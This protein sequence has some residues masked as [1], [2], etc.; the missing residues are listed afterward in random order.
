MLDQIEFREVLKHYRRNLRITQG[1]LASL[2]RVSRPTI[3]NFET[4]HSK[5]SEQS[6]ESVRKAL[7]ELIKDRASAVGF[8]PA[9]PCTLATGVDLQVST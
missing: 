5:L 9:P 7:L 4:G 1:E 8:F 3:A 6:M 2:A